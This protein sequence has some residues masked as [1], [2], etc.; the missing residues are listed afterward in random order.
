MYNVA[1]CNNKISNCSMLGIIHTPPY[2]KNLTCW[3][4]S[5]YRFEIG[6]QDLAKNTCISLGSRQK[7]IFVGQFY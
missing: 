6:G 4:N 7:V 1:I 5:D 2:L 3:L